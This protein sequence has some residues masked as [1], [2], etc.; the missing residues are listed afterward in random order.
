M[1]YDVNYNIE[2]KT[3]LFKHGMH[4]ASTFAR[5]NCS[6][7]VVFNEDKRELGL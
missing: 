3:D 5:E 1:S 7:H 2:V 4:D 6:M